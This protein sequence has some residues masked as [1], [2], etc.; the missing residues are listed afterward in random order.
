MP[1]MRTVELSTYLNAPAAQVWNE[2]N[3]PR[4]LMFVAH[5]V[6]RFKPVDPVTLP[7]LWADGDYVF[8][9]SWY[10]IV[11]LGQQTVSISRPATQGTSKRLR[12]NGYG[13]MA[14]RWDHLICV[15]PQGDGTRYT[16]R[17]EI[18]AGIA[19]PIVAAFAKRFYSHRQRR[20]HKLVEAGFQYDLAALS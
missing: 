2:L 18:D 7:D 10:G 15:T 20:W 13:A 16:D 6:L 19:T 14:K 3:K 12:D 9:L 5:P 17:I 8:S 4:L 11:P 1:T